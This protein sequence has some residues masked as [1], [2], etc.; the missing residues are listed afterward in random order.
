MRKGGGASQGSRKN[1]DVSQ[2]NL[3][4]PEGTRR[5]HLKAWLE[6]DLEDLV[7]SCHPFVWIVRQP[8]LTKAEWIRTAVCGR[9]VEASRLATEEIAVCF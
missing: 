4:E 5:Q 6:S 8:G 1:E 3:K 2:A 7:Q 9:D